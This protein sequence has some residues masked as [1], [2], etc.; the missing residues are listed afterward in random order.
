M[1]TLTMQRLSLRLSF[2][3]TAILVNALVLIW[4]GGALIV[5]PDWFYANVGNFPPFNH[6]YMGDA[7]AFTLPLGIGLLL[8]VRQPYRYRLLIGVG[9]GAALLHAIN[10]IY[11]DVLLHQFTLSQWLVNTWALL[12]MAIILF[13]AL[14]MTR[15]EA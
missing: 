14:I 12:F 7:G 10:H 13:V 2:I 5:I 9:A 3:R 4:A 15:G 1:A 8:A 11:D 6:H